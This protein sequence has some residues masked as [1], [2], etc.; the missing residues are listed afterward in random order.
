[1]GVRIEHQTLVAVEGV[2]HLYTKTHSFSLL[3]ERLLAV[4]RL[5][6]LE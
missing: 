4:A 2:S 5:S 3:R 1:M 6:W